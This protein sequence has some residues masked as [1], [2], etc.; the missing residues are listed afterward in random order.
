CKRVGMSVIGLEVT[1]VHV[2]L[3]P[4]NE[5]SDATFANKVTLDTEEFAALAD[6]IAAQF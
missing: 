6:K 2:H 3:I 5:M 1:H 4:L